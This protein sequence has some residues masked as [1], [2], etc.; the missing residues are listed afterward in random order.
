MSCSLDTYTFKDG[1]GSA[2]PSAS[3][4]YFARSQSGQQTVIKM[5]IINDETF[6]R[7]NMSYLLENELHVYRYIQDVNNK[8]HLS[9]YFLPFLDGSNNCGYD[10]LLK[11]IPKKYHK[12]LDRNIYNLARMINNQ[13]HM[14]KRSITNSSGPGASPTVDVR[15]LTYG[16]IVTKM[17][18]G[19]RELRPH[20]E[21]LNDVSMCERYLTAVVWTPFVVKPVAYK[22]PLVPYR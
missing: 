5:F 8:Y 2:T 13:G 11:F 17:V 18:K 21:Q 7:D 15:N 10:T 19:G 16:Y 9:P 14:P 20:L 4:I 12:N 3:D 1:T 6:A 22:A